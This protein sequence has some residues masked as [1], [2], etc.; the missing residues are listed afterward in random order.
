[1][2]VTAF[3]AII[4]LISGKVE[5]INAGHT[6][7]I[8][9]T[10]SGYNFMHLQKNIVLGIKPDT[11]FISQS[12]VLQANEHLLLYT[13]GVTEAEN[14]FCKFYGEERLLNILQKAK[15]KP[16]DN[17][18][19]ILKDVKKFTKSAPQ[20]DDITMLEF[21][22]YGF[23]PSLLNIEADI[24]NLNVVTD[25]IENDIKKYAISNKEK[26]RIIVAVEEIFTNIS[27]YAY[28]GNLKGGVEISTE[29]A[30]KTY[31]VTFVDGGVKYNPLD[32]KDPEIGINIKD[33]PLGGWG[34][35]IVKKIA[36]K[37]EYIRKNKQNI[38]KIGIDFDK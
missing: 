14:K 6:P 7:L 24:T 2:F 8:M 37:L 26:F 35:Y 27:Q 13:D 18:N 11:K 33:R 19:M 16:A 5:Y 21:A 4:D 29:V 15:T 10:K 22:Y 23:K 30:D 25:F 36:D 31:Y 38:F 32:R 12:I 20:S 34:I 9:K 17:L 28:A 1:M 3:M